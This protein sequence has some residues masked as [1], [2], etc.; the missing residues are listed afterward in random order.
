MNSSDY[1]ILLKA[2]RVS[3]LLSSSSFSNRVTDVIAQH[4]CSFYCPERFHQNA[5]KQT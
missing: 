4:N 1:D 2:G 3:G 5:S